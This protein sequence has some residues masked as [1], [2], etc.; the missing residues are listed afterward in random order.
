MF[1]YALIG[2]LLA[3]LTTLPLAW[4]WQLG[5]VRI[6]VLV[7][8]LAL[9]SSLLIALIGKWI[10]MNIVLEVG[11]VWFIT[12][13]GLFGFLAYRFYRDPERTVP[14]SSNVIVSPADGKV[15]Y[16]RE[17]RNGMLPVS[18]K[19][20]HDYR[21]QELMKTPFY[22]E[23]AVVIGIGMSFLDVHVNR[24]P[25]G[26]RITLQRHFPGLFGSLR[27]TEMVFENER[28][29]T[30]IEQGE[31]QVAIVQIASRLV[32][33]IASF[34]HEGQDVTLGQRIGIIRFGSQVDL[35]LPAREDLKL[36]VQP[37]ELVIAGQ[38]IIATFEPAGSR[39]GNQE[40]LKSTRPE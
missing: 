29:T 12:L 36:K 27:R 4:K 11:L 2:M 21:L 24:A 31:L 22:S 16:I 30:I 23:D 17:S 35:V 1:E 26:G 19:Y 10:S 14:D 38:S 7:V 8:L 9:L 15:I 33:Q 13:A 34:V 20:G 6:A 5:I 18:T 25:I 39:A 3:L 32:H 37:G 28:A 40:L